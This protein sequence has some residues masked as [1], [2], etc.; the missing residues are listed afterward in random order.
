MDQ[1]SIFEIQIEICTR[2]RL[3][4][5]IGSRRTI[6]IHQGLWDLIQHLHILG[7]MAKVLHSSRRTGT[8][9]SAFNLT[10]LCKIFGAADSWRY[11]KP[12]AAPRA[13]TMRVPQSRHF[14]ESPSRQSLRL[15]LD[16]KSDSISAPPFIFI[17]LMAGSQISKHNTD[18]TR[19]RTVTTTH[20]MRMANT[21]S[22]EICFLGYSASSAAG[23]PGRGE[24]ECNY[25]VSKIIC[26]RIEVPRLLFSNATQIVHSKSSGVVG[27]L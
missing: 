7:K 10:S 20:S 13:I 8:T 23:V 24:T 25:K 3:N 15:P 11:S 12:L 14:L 22:L 2:F 5:M 6:E 19:T 27:I 26:S 9:S 17:L 16:M 18:A 1:G 21:T 4:Y